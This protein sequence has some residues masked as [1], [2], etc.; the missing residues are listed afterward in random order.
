MI[1][2]EPFLAFTRKKDK[3]KKTITLNIGS[4]KD[5][6]PD[7]WNLMCFICPSF[8]GYLMLLVSSFHCLS[9]LW[10]ANEC[11]SISAQGTI[12][13]SKMVRVRHGPFSLS[14]PFPLRFLSLPLLILFLLLSFCLSFFFPFSFPFSFLFP[15]PFL[16][17]SFS[18][19]FPFVF[20]S[21]SFLFPFPFPFL[22]LSLS[23]SF[24]FLPLLFLFLFP[25]LAHASPL[26]K[27]WSQR[28]EKRWEEKK[29]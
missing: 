28:W 12:T 3:R 5:L 8:R 14:S 27:V 4:V 20:I 22:F 16:F 13:A 9:S 15:F 18:F 7:S 17:L 24:L 6:C 2:H 23:Y 26:V 10:R 11:V 25:F 19:C 1:P 29:R 21:L